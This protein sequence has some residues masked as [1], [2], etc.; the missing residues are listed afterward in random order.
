MWTFFQQSL[1][2]AAESLVDQGALVPKA[3][4]PRGAIPASSVTVQ[5]ITFLC[6][7]ALLA[8][9]A[10]ALRGS[11]EPALLLLPVLAA[12]LFCFVLGCSLIAAVLHAYYRDVAPILTAALLPW[13]FITPTLF[14]PNTIGFVQ[15]HPFIGTL[16][17][18]VNPVAP[19]VVGF[20]SVLYYGTAPWG[21]LLYAMVAAIAAL[22]LGGSVFR[23]RQG[24]LAV[25]L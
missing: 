7:M 21:E 4:F 15:G 22:A 23:R 6:I 14:E 1:L 19:F 25:V 18:W 5:L 11:L 2:A 16:L 13:F 3:R 10:V 17:E 24:E 8:P 20:R 9:V 12:L